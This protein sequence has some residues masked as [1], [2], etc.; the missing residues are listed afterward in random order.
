MAAFQTDFYAASSRRPRDAMVQTW[1]KFHRQWFGHDDIVALTVELL[2]KVSCL[3]RLGSY[4]SYKND[5]SRIKE[6]HTE[7]EYE[8]TGQL[9]NAARRCARSVLRGLGG[10]SGAW[11]DP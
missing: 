2:E 3:F 4:K 7:C 11:E 10:P 8:W 1:T 5:L 6:I 9:H